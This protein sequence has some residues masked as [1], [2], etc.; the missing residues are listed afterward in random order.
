MRCCITKNTR[1]DGKRLWAVTPNPLTPTRYR[2]E[3]VQQGSAGRYTGIHSNLQY[4]I[5]TGFNTGSFLKYCHTVFIKIL[6]VVVSSFLKWQISNMNELYEKRGTTLQ[7]WSFFG[8]K[9][10][11]DKDNE[12]VVCRLCRK[13]VLA[14]GGNTSNLVSHLKNHHP[15]EHCTSIKGGKGKTS[16]KSSDDSEPKTKQVTLK[17][18][19]ERTQPYLRSSRRWQEIT[20]SVTNFIAKE[21]MPVNIVE[22]QGFKDMVRKLDCRYEIP[23]RKYFSKNALPS[24]Y[25]ATYQKIADSMKGLDYFSITADMW[26]SGKM[27][28]YLAVTIHYIDRDWNLKSHCLQTLFVP[29]DHTAENLAPLLRTTLDSWCLLE[30]RLACITTDN[31]SNIIAAMRILK[32]DR[33]AITCTWPLQI[34]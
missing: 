23:S 34:Q 21:M 17:E 28:P 12:N 20:T 24:L 10:K 22:R 32:W 2:Q 8:L 18:A 7:V 33:L 13:S 14:R 27:E 16:E 9:S 25:V 11:E 3:F 6:W 26:S 29:E 15:N 31:G 19:V 1:L 30:N 4:F 5:D